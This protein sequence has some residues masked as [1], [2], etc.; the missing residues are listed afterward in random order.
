MFKELL[1]LVGSQPPSFVIN[2]SHFGKVQI[3]RQIFAQLA[4][5]ILN[6][7][8]SAVQ[9]EN[10]CEFWSKQNSFRDPH[11]KKSVK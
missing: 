1:T 8:V 2:A 3:L 9:L 6:Y 7:V 4:Y 11:W 10:T 5:Q